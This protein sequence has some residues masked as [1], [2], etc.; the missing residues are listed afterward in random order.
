MFLFSGWNE[1]S[2]LE[3]RLKEKDIFDVGF[4][5]ESI[6]KI[7]CL[8]SSVASGTQQ[9]VFGPMANGV[10]KIILSTNIAETSV[11]VS[12]INHF[13]FFPSNGHKIILVYCL[14]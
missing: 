5:N 13:I 9:E 8:H 14:D 2:T 7:F 12:F 6:C 11:T 1:I 3:K 4:A 10:R